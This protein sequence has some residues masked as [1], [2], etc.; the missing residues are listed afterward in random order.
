MHKNLLNALIEAIDNREAAALVTVTSGEGAFAHAVGRNAVVRPRMD[1]C[2]EGELGLGKWN[3]S[4]LRDARS[5][6]ASKKHKHFNY[7]EVD[8]RFSVFVEV[9]PRPPHL[10]IAGAGHIAVPL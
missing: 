8:G 5:A 7:E 6:V 3:E 1:S 10:I 2:P 4:V 9:Q